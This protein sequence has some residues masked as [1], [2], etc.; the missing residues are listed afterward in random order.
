MATPKVQH[1]SKAASDKL[2]IKFSDVSVYDFVYSSGNGIRSPVVYGVTSQGLGLGSKGTS[3]KKRAAE[4]RVRFEGIESPRSS[5]NA[6]SR[7]VDSIVSWKTPLNGS[8][9]KTGLASQ[10]R[11]VGSLKSS[12]LTVAQMK[13]YALLSAAAEKAWR[14]ALRGASRCMMEKHSVQPVRLR[15]ELL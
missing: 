6:S 3:K 13:T 12:Q 8:V 10:L 11:S 7:E 1:V 4:A 15:K 9:R 5:S 2:L 14:K